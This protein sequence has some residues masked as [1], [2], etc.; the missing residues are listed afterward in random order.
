MS[1]SPFELFRRYLRPLMVF[2]TLLALFAFVVLPALQG[3]LQRS[4]GIVDPTLATYDGTPMKAS[5]VETFTRNHYE[6]V[7][8]LRE[9]AM[10]TIRRKGMQ[11]FL[12]GRP[13]IWRD[14]KAGSYR[15][16]N[17]FRRT[18]NHCCEELN[19]GA[20]PNSRTSPEKL[21]NLTI[22]I[23]IGTTNVLAAPKNFDTSINIWSSASL[24]QL[25]S[26]AD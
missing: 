14:A 6:I 16:L 22:G 20:L 8:F 17:V 10:E 13:R 26:G 15:P 19:P 4:G 7:N 24:R 1:N 18:E 25:K 5:R 11:R 2:L 21:G 23:P 12:V 9:V 3:Y